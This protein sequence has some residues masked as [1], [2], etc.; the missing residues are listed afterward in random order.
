MWTRK[1]QASPSAVCSWKHQ[2]HSIIVW[3]MLIMVSP[4]SYVHTA[5]DSKVGSWPEDI[6]QHY[7]TT[8]GSSSLFQIYI[9]K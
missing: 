3:F 8:R 2:M 5:K 4:Y 6:L 9:A 1:R 7:L